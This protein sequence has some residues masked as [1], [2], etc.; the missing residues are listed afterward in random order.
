MKRR[1]PTIPGTFKAR[2]QLN[3]FLLGCHTIP[4]LVEGNFFAGLVLEPFAMY[5]VLTSR[6]EQFVIGTGTELTD[7]EIISHFPYWTCMCVGAHVHGTCVEVRRQ[8]CNMIL[9]YHVGSRD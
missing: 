6:Q 9:S 1:I 2:Q 5:S 8:L 7:T 4:G 3:S